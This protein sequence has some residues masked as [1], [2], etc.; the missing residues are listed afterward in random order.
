LAAFSMLVMILEVVPP[1]LRGEIS[2]WL[3]PVDASVFV[4]RVSAE[5]RDLLWAS[6]VER[7]G[8]GRAMQIWQAKGEQGFSMRAHN[9][10]QRT[11]VDTEGLTLVA[12]QDAAW[13]QA[14]ERFKLPVSEAPVRQP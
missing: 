11:L 3:M 12:V 4:G 9:L 14:V 13:R 6:T 10:A 1:S 7:I 2:R 8:S 5:V